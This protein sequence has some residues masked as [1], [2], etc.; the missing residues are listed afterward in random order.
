MPKGG[1]FTKVIRGGS[2][3]VGDQI[4]RMSKYGE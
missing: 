2:V 4:R 1:V 3:R